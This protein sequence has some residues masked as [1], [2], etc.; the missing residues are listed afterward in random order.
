LGRGT[1]KG[2]CNDVGDIDPDWGKKKDLVEGEVSIVG[3]TG[4][5]EEERDNERALV[6]VAVPEAGG[7]DLGGAVTEPLGER[8]LDDPLELEEPLE[9]FDFPDLLLLV[10]VLVEC[11]ELFDRVDQLEV[12]DP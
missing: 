12:C 8:G 5:K 2:T 3:F 6:G 1:L 11:V 7:D 9:F 4:V 10:P